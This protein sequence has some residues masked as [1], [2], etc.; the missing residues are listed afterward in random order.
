[1]V[2]KINKNVTPLKKPIRGFGPALVNRLTPRGKH[3][4]KVVKTK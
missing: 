2:T 4:K 1:M 3:P